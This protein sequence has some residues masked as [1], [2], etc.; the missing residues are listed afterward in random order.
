[1]GFAFAEIAIIEEGVVPAGVPC[2]R[3]VEC[4]LPVKQ[5]RGRWRRWHVQG[6]QWERSPDRGKG[7]W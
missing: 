2:F 5:R 1:M 4:E 7:M 6:M 3:R